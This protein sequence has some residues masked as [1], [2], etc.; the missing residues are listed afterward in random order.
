MLQLLNVPPIVGVTFHQ[1]TLPIDVDPATGAWLAVAA[2]NT[3][4]LV[5]GIF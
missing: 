3:P 5:G 2:T 4:Q 1:Q